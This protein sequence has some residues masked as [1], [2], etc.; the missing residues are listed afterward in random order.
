MRQVPSLPPEERHIDNPAHAV[1]ERDTNRASDRKASRTSKFGLFAVL[2][3]IYLAVGA[4]AV[5]AGT[6]AQVT[7][8]APVPNPDGRIGLDDV[9][10]G[11]PAGQSTSWATLAANSGARGDRWELRWDRIEPKRGVWT[12]SADDVAVEQA[13][14]A[15]MDVLGILIGTPKWADASGQ[16]PGNGVPAGLQYAVTDPR[17]RWA[18]YVRATVQHYQTQIHEWEIWNEPDLGFFWSGT[19]SDYAALLSEAYEVI[20]Q[21]EPVSTVVMAG[22]VVPGLAF[23]SQVLDAIHLMKPVPFDVA[24]WHAYGP[25]RKLFQNIEAM[26]SAL[27]T[28]G[29][30]RV[31]IWVTESGFPAA[32][33]NGESRQAAYVLQSTAYAFLAHAARVFIYR[34]SDDTTSRQW[35]LMASDGQ[36]RMGYVA[37]QVAA[38]YFAGIQDFV[39][40]PTPSAE[41]IIGYGAGRTVLIAWS[42]SASAAA[43]HLPPAPRQAVVDWQGNAVIPT[44]STSGI[45]I[46]LPAPQYNTG[47]IDP[48]NSVVGGPP[49]IAS[50]PAPADAPAPIQSVLTLD[51]RR[52]PRIVILNVGSTAADAAAQS[53]SRPDRVVP[54]QVAPNGL[55]EVDS[56]LLGGSGHVVIRSSTPV[57]ALAG[58]G[59]VATTAVQPSATW[60]VPAPHASVEVANPNTGSVS[61]RAARY[62]AGGKAGPV[63]NLVI[64]ATRT[65]MVTPQTGYEGSMRLVASAPVSVSPVSQGAVQPQSQWS[66]IHPSGNRFTVWNVGKKTASADIRFVGSH[67]VTTEH[68]QLAPHASFSGKAY[69]AFVAVVTADSPVVAAAGAGTTSPSTQATVPLA[70]RQHLA[71]FNPSPSAVQVTFRVT[72]E[73]S[74]TAGTRII[75]G[76]HLTNLV[77]AT[78]KSSVVTVSSDRPVSAVDV[79]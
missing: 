53:L 4:R 51:P 30:G 50:E 37:L 31:P 60:Y 73:G 54:A 75:R 33:P 27:R 59:Q 35:G 43:V 15:G 61:I 12:F 39:E 21:V 26:R 17:N 71:L 44:S 16:R 58:S 70:P 64:P 65:S 69:G 23:F 52:H 49:V 1:N 14:Q 55:T 42:V 25:A 40:A 22:M 63:Q 57:L 18:A 77:P 76:M 10:P 7:A 3:V 8:L 41:R 2:T 11:A 47:G 20:K 38:S 68:V 36:P 48:T 19:P 29:L 74:N 28:H 46:P 9:L 24:A 67:S 34:A 6:G 72:R 32:D 56:A 5:P 62:S 79:P 66:L 45:R 13:T 78:A